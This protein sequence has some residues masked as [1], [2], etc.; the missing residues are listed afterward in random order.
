MKIYQM[1]SSY[2]FNF[3]FFP[4]TS[5]GACQTSGLVCQNGGLCQDSTGTATCVCPPGYTGQNCESQGESQKFKKCQNLK[6]KFSK[7]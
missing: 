6:A 4:V 3:P 1:W 7:I 5:T 2:L